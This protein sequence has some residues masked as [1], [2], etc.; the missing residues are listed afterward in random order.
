MDCVIIGAGGHGRVVL[1]IMQHE[2]RHEVVGFPI[3]TVD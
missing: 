1:D 2:G 3:C